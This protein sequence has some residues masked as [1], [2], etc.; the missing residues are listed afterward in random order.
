M[1]FLYDMFQNRNA[2]T[3]T[4]NNISVDT[5]RIS[6]GIFDHMNIL[7]LLN[8]ASNVFDTNK[9]SGWTSNTLLNATFDETLNG[10]SIGEFVGFI[11]HLEVQR[12][13]T[14]SNEWITLQKIYKNKETEEINVPFTFVDTYTK[15]NTR[16]KYQVLPIDLSGNAGTALQSE[17][18]SYF[19]DAY[20]ADAS[21]I[22]K[23]TCEYG[24]NNKQTNNISTIYTPY[25]SKYPF[26]AFNAETPHRFGT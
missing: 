3:P 8:I 11:D 1:F 12:Q 19:N 7:N 18:L 20:I 14:G 15:N 21:H 5:I 23:I 24:I 25:G 9:P 16:Y 22:Y 10:G 26:V 17:T 4:A 13:E 2:L 6:K